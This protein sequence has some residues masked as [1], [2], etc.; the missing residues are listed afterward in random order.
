MV[1]VVPHPNR[2]AHLAAIV[3]GLV[4]GLIAGPALV[5]ALLENRDPPFG[6]DGFGGPIM[7]VG[8]RVARYDP[9][10]LDR[11]FEPTK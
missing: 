11:L 8:H 9:R 10:E 6:D 2:L 5:A 4:G 7:H 3:V 1:T